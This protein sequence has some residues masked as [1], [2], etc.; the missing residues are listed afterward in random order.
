MPK[1]SRITS[2]NVCYTKLL[3][4]LEAQFLQLVVY[5]ANRS[6]LQIL[7]LVVQFGDTGDA[8]LQLGVQIAVNRLTLLHDPLYITVEI[9]VGTAFQDR[10]FL[11]LGSGQNI[12]LQQPTEIE[13]V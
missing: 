11:G 13:I 5:A 6:G 1:R 3:R 2:Y 9:T 7:C 12:G 8:R 10:Q 4:L